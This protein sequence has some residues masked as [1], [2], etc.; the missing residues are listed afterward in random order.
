M[1][2]KRF[3]ER[4]PLFLTASAFKGD[5]EAG[6]W[7]VA[8]V[9]VFWEVLFLLGKK[10]PNPNQTELLLV[11]PME[12]F[13]MRCSAGSKPRLAEHWLWRPD[14]SSFCPWGCSRLNQHLWSKECGDWIVCIYSVWKLKFPRCPF[15]LVVL[16]LKDRKIQV[17]NWLYKSWVTGRVILCSWC[18]TEVRAR[19]TFG[20]FS[21]V[22]FRFHSNIRSGQ[23]DADVFFSWWYLMKKSQTCWKSKWYGNINLICCSCMHSEGFFQRNW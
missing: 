18:D 8:G 16:D 3:G 17:A 9:L 6:G 23:R 5:V 13:W 12:D 19:K 10:K 20:R 21:M 11:F 15:V 2:N 22:F 14:P 4:V 7:V 1:L